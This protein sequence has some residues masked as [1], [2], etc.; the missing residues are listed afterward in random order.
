VALFVNP[1]YALPRFRSFSLGKREWNHAYSQ[2]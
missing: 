1:F 2:R